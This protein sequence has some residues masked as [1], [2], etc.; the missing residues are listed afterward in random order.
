MI[1]VIDDYRV[2]I[3]FSS[4]DVVIQHLESLEVLDSYKRHS[5][6][7]TCLESSILLD[8]RGK[9]REVL[10][11]GGSEK[12]CSIMVYNLEEKKAITRL[13]GHQNL[14]SAVRDLRDGRTIVTASFDTQISF[15]DL[16]GDFRCI[17]LLEEHRSPVLA[18]D[19]N[20]KDNVLCSGDLEGVINIWEVHFKDNKFY[21]CQI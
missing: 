12:E 21:G 5:S 7:I 2:A 14:V 18:L 19:F 15:W 16:K 10:L 8:S 20:H 4:G 9:C 3:G 11:S 17:L 1:K 6:A 13:T